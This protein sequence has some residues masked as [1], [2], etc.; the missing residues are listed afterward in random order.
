MSASRR[1]ESGFTLVEVLLALLIGA[2]VMLGSYSV[3]SQVIGLSDD[4]RSNL[5]AEDA[6]DIL[7]IAL[8]NDLGSIIWV[9][10]TIRRA[11]ES[12]AFSGGRQETALSGLDEEVILSLASAAVLAPD[13]PFPSHAFNRVT[14]LLR[15]PPGKD[16]EKTDTRQLVRRELPAATLAWR[17]PARP[18]A[19]ETVLL[20]TVSAC[21]IQFFDQSAA[22]TTWDSQARVQARQSP[23]PTQVRLQGEAV[24]GGKTRRFE[25]RS[26]LP[27]RNLA[28]GEGR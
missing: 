7:R 3:T 11:A 28:V 20:E 16:G 27:F 6:L 2:L 25:V 26:A 9:E 15:K 1:H 19:H 12:M 24:L 13:A 17:D 18:S 21:A 8:D 22:L 5:A 4:V 23:L 14:Y 10:S